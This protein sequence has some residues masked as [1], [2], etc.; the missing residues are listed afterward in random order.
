MNCS[1]CGYLLRAD[2]KFCR[3]CGEAVSNT[4]PA[5]WL[6]TKKPEMPAELEADPFLAVWLAATALALM[7]LTSF[8]SE[9]Q[10]NQV[11][12]GLL[13]YFLSG[14]ALYL[15]ISGKIKHKI[16]AGGI[17]L[18]ASFLS[19][20][21]SVMSRVMMATRQYIPSRVLSSLF[22]DGRF[23]FC[24]IFSAIVFAIGVVSPL[25]FKTDIK[26]RAF[27]TGLISAGAL[28]AYIFIRNIIL[29]LPNSDF[30]Y[31]FINTLLSSVVNAAAL[32]LSLIAVNM[33]CTLRSYKIQTGAGRKA[34]FALCAVVSTVSLIAQNVIE[35]ANRGKM[36][37]RDNAFILFV[38]ISAGIFGY[39]QLLAS[40]R[41]GY[42]VILMAIG[43]IFFTNFQINVNSL[44]IPFLQRKQLNVLA[45]RDMLFSLTVLVNPFITS[46]TLI[47]VWKII[48]SELPREKRRVPVAFKVFSVIGLVSSFAVFFT[49]ALDT[50]GIFSFASHQAR[51]FMAFTAGGA[52]SATLQVFC[53][54]SCFGKNAKAPRG[55]LVTGAVFA[56][57]ITIFAA[58][59]TAGIIFG[60]PMNP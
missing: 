30:F 26:K 27:Y 58:G 36:P 9:W 8:F 46:M 1:Q 24:L 34:W 39:I 33:F 49:G 11:A 50:Y 54:A 21:I 35:I 28:I 22:T 38:L 16:Y 3:N 45:F 55:L 20:Y 4:A 18:L 19:A 15:M 60:A 13:F 2:A 6:P 48:P 44:L 14:C 17:L 5:W 32:F 40:K 25:I 56:V 12:C 51:I 52:A 29:I 43:L 53:A 31:A 10:V 57:I 42:P 37:L 47:G 41:S 59:M 7:L 23:V